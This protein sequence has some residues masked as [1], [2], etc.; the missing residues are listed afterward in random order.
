VRRRRALAAFGA[1]TLSTASFGQTPAKL[2]RVGLLIDGAANHPIA[3]AVPRELAALGYVAGR[4]VAFDIRATDSRVERLPDLAQAQVRAGADVI[5]AHFT[6]PVRAAMA[7]T[8]DIP[9]V[10]APAGAPV[11]LGLVASLGRPEGNVTGITN[12]AAEL[13]GRR[14][15]ILRDLGLRRVTVLV[16]PADTFTKPFL[17]YME[18][19]ADGAGVTLNAVTIGEASEFEAAFDVMQRNRVQAAIVPATFDAHQAGLIELAARRQIGLMAINHSMTR[20]GGLASIAG[21]TDEIYRRAA[22]FVDRLLKGA[23]PSS[24][25]VE[26]P[27]TFELALNLKTA[28]QLGLS[29]PPALLLAATEVIE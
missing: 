3:A 15:Q 12:M 5:V 20:A 24:L 28:R 7:A 22:Y 27:T 18:A 13:G 29:V 4:N 8:K 25:P 9:I 16:S 21:S 2:H 26:Q 14:L 23:K 17:H 6:P 10:M 1:L 11:E 19:A